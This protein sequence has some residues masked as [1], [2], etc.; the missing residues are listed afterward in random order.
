[1]LGQ[2]ATGVFADNH[3][4][5]GFKPTYGVI[6]ISVC[7]LC[8]CKCIHKRM[9]ACAYCLMTL[10]PRDRLTD[11]SNMYFEVMARVLKRQGL[12]VRI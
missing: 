8:K 7:F 4:W 3:I 6:W 5:V 11:F 2:H 10:P 1:M 12:S 9:C